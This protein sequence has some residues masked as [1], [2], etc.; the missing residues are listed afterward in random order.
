[1]RRTTVIACALLVLLP[2]AAGAVTVTTPHG[3]SEVFARGDLLDVLALLRLA[4]AEVEFA[5]AAGSYT[6]AS[7]DH[8]IQFTPGGSLAVVDGRLTPLPGPLRQLEGHVVGAPATVAEL[9]GPVR[10]HGARGRRCAPSSPRSVAASRSRSS[11]VRAATGTTVVL[12]GTKQ[13]P[14]VTPSPAPSRSSS[15]RQ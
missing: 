11:V 2:M 12:R 15:R 8:Q 9:L 4:G 1:M 6:A 3:P 13:R 10:L 7:A 5:A 14:K